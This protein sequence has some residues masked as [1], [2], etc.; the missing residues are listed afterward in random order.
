MTAAQAQHLARGANAEQQALEFLQA[1]GLK[2]VERN[3]RCRLGEIDLICEDGR[4]LVFIEVRF[5]QH[6]HYGTAAETVTPHKQ[7]KLIRTAQHFLQHHPR[8]ARNP[9]RFDVIGVQ[10]PAGN[11]TIDW[12]KDAFQT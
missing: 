5:R 7:R 9:A 1:H 11:A 12:I 2:I 3:Y 6:H 10:G 8:R 4:W